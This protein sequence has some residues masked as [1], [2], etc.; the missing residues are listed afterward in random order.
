MLGHVVHPAM[1]RSPNPNS[2]TALPLLTELT[3]ELVDSTNRY[4]LPSLPSLRKLTLVRKMAK[5]HLQLPISP[6]CSAT[7]IPPPM[8]PILAEVLIFA[9]NV[10]ASS[11]HHFL[12][13]HAKTLTSFTI[14]T[15]TDVFNPY[16][17]PRRLHPAN[18]VI[19]SGATK[20]L[21]Q[22]PPYADTRPSAS[23]DVFVVNLHSLRKLSIRHLTAL[24]SPHVHVW[25]CRALEELELTFPPRLPPPTSFLTESYTSLRKLIYRFPQNTFTRQSW[26]YAL[27]IDPDPEVVHEQGSH[28]HLLISLLSKLP[29]LEELVIDGWIFSHTWGEVDW[30]ETLMP[31]SAVPLQDYGVEYDLDLIEDDPWNPDR[32]R[33]PPNRAERRRERWETQDGKP[34]SV[35]NAKVS[36]AGMLLDET[37]ETLVY[38]GSEYSSDEDEDHAETGQENAEKHAH[39]SPK[40]SHSTPLRFNPIST[41]P[42]ELLCPRLTRLE[43]RHCFGVE[44]SSMFISLRERARLAEESFLLGKVEENWS[45]ASYSGSSGATPSHANTSPIA[46]QRSDASPGVRLVAHDHAF[47]SASASHI[48][49]CAQVIVMTYDCAL[50]DE[51]FEELYAQFLRGDYVVRKPR[52]SRETSLILGDRNH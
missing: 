47:Q 28:S 15:T 49:S 37:G 6:W 32:K 33:R 14:H 43:L 45:P 24:F 23:P 8:F 20:A 40:E 41:N 16:I 3:L 17:I 12:I 27:S 50:T 13:A 7:T 29:T 2:I 11:L 1:P 34:F 46:N 10:E 52:K 22:V 39:Q 5:P 51:E 18:F 38:A 21:V 36:D 30:M 26:A 9:S 25:A 35:K 31:P 44:R 4:I 19:S 48:E 42:T